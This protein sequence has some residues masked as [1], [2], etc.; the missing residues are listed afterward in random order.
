MNERTKDK[1]KNERRINERINKLIDNSRERHIGVAAL[2]RVA[3][4]TKAK[5]NKLT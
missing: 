2:P 3:H 1:Q 4:I 5:G